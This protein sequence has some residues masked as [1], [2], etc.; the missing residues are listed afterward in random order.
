MPKYT[1]WLTYTI[2]MEVAEGSDAVSRVTT[3]DWAQTFYD[4]MTE[5]DG[6]AMLA[7]LCGVDGRDLG[8]L[9][10]WADLPN[11]HVSIGRVDVYTDSVE[12]NGEPLDLDRDGR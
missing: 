12:W 4:G 6:A 2:E 8:S 5:G 7:R 9:D 3:E 10:G 1:V 11:E